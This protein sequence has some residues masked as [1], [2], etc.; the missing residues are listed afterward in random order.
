MKERRRLLFRQ[1]DT[2]FRARQVTP[3]LWTT[4]VVTIPALAFV[5]GLMMPLIALEQFP[6]ALVVILGTSPSFVRVLVFGGAL[7]LAS[8]VTAC[9]LLPVIYSR[10]GRKTSRLITVFLYSVVACGVGNVVAVGLVWKGIAG[11]GRDMLPILVVSAFNNT[12]A[13]IVGT[14]VNRHLSR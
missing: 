7:A 13:G 5:Y 2:V 3:N 6:S 1:R 9:V 10:W 4:A 14:I 12:T 8:S 11:Y